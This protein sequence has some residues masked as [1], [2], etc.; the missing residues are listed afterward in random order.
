MSKRLSRR[1][2]LIVKGFEL[3]DREF[4]DKSTEFV[5]SIVCDRLEVD[6]SEVIDALANEARIKESTP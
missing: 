6:W 5:I 1:E 2:R 4:P 3:A